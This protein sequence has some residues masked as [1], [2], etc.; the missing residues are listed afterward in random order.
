MCIYSG[1]MAIIQR[2]HRSCPHSVWGLLE[3]GCSI[4]A[5]RGLR[6]CLKKNFRAQMLPLLE[7][8]AIFICKDKI[9]MS[10]P[11]S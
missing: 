11:F 1:G 3:I 8:F 7:Y 10:C 2:K 9:S 4:A 5:L 6:I